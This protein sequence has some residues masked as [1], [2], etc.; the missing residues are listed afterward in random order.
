MDV[1]AKSFPYLLLALLPSY[2]LSPRVGPRRKSNCVAGA[3]G[4][5]IGSKILF[6]FE[7]KIGNI[8]PMQEDTA[9][10]VNSIWEQLVEGEDGP[11]V[12]KLWVSTKNT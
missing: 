9:I 4:N 12:S 2:H 6:Y 1:Y 7:L 8:P 3:A 11:I 10:H 5:E